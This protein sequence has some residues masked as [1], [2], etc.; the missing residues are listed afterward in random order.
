[1]KYP[2]VNYIGNKE[3][4]VEWISSLIPADATSLLD[5]FAGGC[6]VAYMAKQKGLQV[7]ANDI[8]KIDYHLAKALIENTCERLTASDVE[9]LFEGIPFR[10]FMCE[11]YANKFY[12]EDECMQL[13]LFR[14]NVGCLSSEYKRSLAWALMRRAMIRKMPYSRF[15][16]KWEKIQQLRDEELSYALYGRRRAYHNKSFRFHFEKALAEY[17]AAVFDNGQENRAYNLDVFDVLQQVRADVVYLDPP[18]A[19]T[20]NDY[21]AF[22]GLIDSYITGTVSEPFANNFMDQGTIAQ[23]FDRLFASL[24]H[25]KY[26]MLSYNSRSKPT[27]DELLRIISKYSTNVEVHEMPYAYR[28]TGKEK[29]KKDTEYL[30]IAKNGNYEK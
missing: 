15:T 5:A 26:W 8:L 11:H 14:S 17:N 18:Y 25:F 24:G 21:H 22:Y 27:K 10:G 13:D 12:F 2:T 4:I 6:S 7:F 9:M 19:G 30:F 16:I 29:K 20:M 3:K 23:L 28:V 1:M